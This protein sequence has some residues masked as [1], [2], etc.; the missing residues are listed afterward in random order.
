MS[1]G[2]IFFPSHAESSVMVT[3]KGNSEGVSKAHDFVLWFCAL[4]ISCF[5][6]KV[7]TLQ[8]H[9]L[10]PLI[11]HHIPVAIVSRKKRDR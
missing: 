1:T 4:V 2:N 9:V 10:I 3:V 7:T 6:L 8:C 11:N 5:M